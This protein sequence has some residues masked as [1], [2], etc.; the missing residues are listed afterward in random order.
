MSCEFSS[1]GWFFLTINGWKDEFCELERDV[2]VLTYTN[3]DGKLAVNL[4]RIATGEKDSNELSVS[5]KDGDALRFFGRF[6]YDAPRDLFQDLSRRYPSCRFTVEADWE[7][8]TE[9]RVYEYRS[10]HERLVSRRQQGI[11]TLCDPRTQPVVHWDIRFEFESPDEEVRVLDSIREAGLLYS[12]FVNRVSVSEVLDWINRRF[13]DVTV[14]DAGS[15][16]LT[17]DEHWYYHDLCDGIVDENSD[18]ADG[19][20]KIS[21]RRNEDFRVIERA[22]LLSDEELGYL[23]LGLAE[24]LRHEVI[25][26][27]SLFAVFVRLEQLRNHIGRDICDSIFLSD[28]ED[29]MAG[30]RDV[31]REEVANRDMPINGKQVFRAWFTEPTAEESAELGYGRPFEPLA[32][33]IGMLL[34]GYPEMT[35]ERRQELEAALASPRWTKEWP[36]ENYTDSECTSEGDGEPI[37]EGHGEPICD[38]DFLKELEAFGD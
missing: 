23:F 22:I 20:L 6:A 10:G 33:E 29:I 37:S 5:P 1:H 30:I 32:G 31:D 12:G 4:G 28:I 9:S 34:R 35:T 27:E 11:F 25:S 8:E 19:P 2:E 15:V 3:S 17:L 36:E 16:P 18:F 13:P 14:Q 24:R 38:E 7:V 21:D 26:R